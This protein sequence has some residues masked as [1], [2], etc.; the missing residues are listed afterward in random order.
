MEFGDWWVIVAAYFCVGVERNE[1]CVVGEDR[2][3]I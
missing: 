1:Y 2:V 3:D